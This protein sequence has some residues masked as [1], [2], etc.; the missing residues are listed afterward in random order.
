[1]KNG[2]PPFYIFIKSEK[3][4]EET[5]GEVTATKI[6]ATHTKPTASDGT[7]AFIEASSEFAY[8]TPTHPDIQK[9][10]ETVSV[11][12]S[13]KSFRPIIISVST[14]AVFLCVVLMTIKTKKNK[15]F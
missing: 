15:Q 1:M 8:A 9:T 11:E 5:T 14:A 2:K 12:G 10:E 13:E 6:H 3:T 7:T 4:S